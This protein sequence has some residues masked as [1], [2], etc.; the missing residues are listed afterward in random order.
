M[1]A[2]FTVLMPLHI[3]LKNHVTSP[4]ITTQLVVLMDDKRKRLLQINSFVGNLISR[5]K[6]ILNSNKFIELLYLNCLFC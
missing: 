3:L 1:N 2:Q 6:T 4:T 5:N